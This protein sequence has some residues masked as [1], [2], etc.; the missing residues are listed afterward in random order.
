MIL[1][2][3][4]VTILEVNIMFSVFQASLS[5]FDSGQTAALMSQ[6]EQRTVRLGVLVLQHH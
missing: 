2:E 1:G 5:I 4:P 6:V 3:V